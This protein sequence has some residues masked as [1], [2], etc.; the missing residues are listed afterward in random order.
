MRA[1]IMLLCPVLT[2]MTLAFATTAAEA[3]ERHKRGA[4]SCS[5]LNDSRC[6]RGDVRPARFGPQVRL[7]GGTWIDCAGDCRDTLR[8]QTVDFWYEQMLNQ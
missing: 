6:V 5:K 2:I 1:S 4:Y 8:K 3:K 7:P